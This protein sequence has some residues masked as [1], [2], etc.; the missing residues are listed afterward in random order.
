MRYFSVPYFIDD[1]NKSIFRGDICLHDFCW[2]TNINLKK[3]NLLECQCISHKSTKL[4]TLYLRPLVDTELP[5]PS[6]HS[7]TWRSQDFVVRYQVSLKLAS[8]IALRNWVE[9][10]QE[11]GA[12]TTRNSPLTSP[13]ICPLATSTGASTI[14]GNFSQVKPQTNGRNTVGRYM[15]RPCCWELLCKVWNWS[16]FWTNNSQHFLNSVITEA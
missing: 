14:G 16:N 12:K 9:R 5:F 3:R 4:K 7:S 2:I 10:P 11:N 1:M 13:L 8:G 15:L 6:N